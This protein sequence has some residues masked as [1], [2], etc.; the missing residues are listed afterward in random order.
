MELK[1]CPGSNTP[2]SCKLLIVPYGIETSQN[3]KSSLFWSGLLIVPY[4]IE[5]TL[6][7]FGENYNL[8]LIVPYGIETYNANVIILPGQTFNRTLWN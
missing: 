1:L 4:G 3:G 7:S 2:F 5:T 6:Y 8:L